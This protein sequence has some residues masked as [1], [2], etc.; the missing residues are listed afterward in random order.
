[1][2]TVTIWF[3]LLSIAVNQVIAGGGSNLLTDEEILALT[4]KTKSERVS[5]SK[6]V[7]VSEYMMVLTIWTLKCCM[8]TIYGRIT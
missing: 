4:P 1:M 5:G 6:W 2:L 8:L 7:Y 3:T